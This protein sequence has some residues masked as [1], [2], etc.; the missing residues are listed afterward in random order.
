MYIYIHI[1]FFSIISF[2]FTDTDDSWDSRRR[3]KGGRPL[4]A[5]VYHLRQLT[6]IQVFI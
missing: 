4:F 6:N 3:E 1:Y 5:P 2:S